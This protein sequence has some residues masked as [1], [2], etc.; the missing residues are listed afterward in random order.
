[1]YSSNKIKIYTFNQKKF[2]RIVKDGLFPLP[3]EVREDGKNDDYWYP[4]G[5]G[6]IYSSF[7][8]S[9]LYEKFKNDG[10]EYIFISNI[11][12][13]GATIDLNILNFLIKNN[14]DFCMEVTKKSR[15][16]VKGILIINE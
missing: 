16:D 7:Y 13:L 5:H 8:D 14:T 6:D 9:N 4:P 10:K 11:D 2:P 3:E 1:M 15:A 12:N